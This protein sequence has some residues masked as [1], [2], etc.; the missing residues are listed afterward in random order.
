MYC[1]AADWLNLWIHFLVF[2]FFLSLNVC[3]SYIAEYSATGKLPADSRKRKTSSR[4]LLVVATVVV[5]NDKYILSGLS[6]LEQFAYITLVKF[7]FVSVIP[8]HFSTIF[9]VFYSHRGNQ[10]DCELILE[11]DISGSSEDTSFCSCQ[12]LICKD[13]LTAVIRL[14]KIN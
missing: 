1:R 10:V 3:L 7:I 5:Y 13:D 12:R 14:M 6:Q 8:F 4:F 9:T 11:S 2:S